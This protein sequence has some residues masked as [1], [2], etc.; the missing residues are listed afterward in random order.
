LI[1]GPPFHFLG[2]DGTFGPRTETL[3]KEFQ[4]EHGLTADGIVG[5]VTWGASLGMGNVRLATIV[6]L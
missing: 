5:L 3:V 2:E 1:A 4:T 6:G